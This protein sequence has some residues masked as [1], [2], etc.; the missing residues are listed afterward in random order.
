MV[1]RTVWFCYEGKLIG[2]H[3]L[4]AQPIGHAPTA[5]A[6][7]EYGPRKAQDVECRKTCGRR[8]K[9]TKILRMS[10]STPRLALYQVS[11]A[12]RFNGRFLCTFLSSI[13]C[14]AVAHGASRVLLPGTL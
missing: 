5:R 13:H 10:C 8:V 6:Q 4:H 1:D 7:A 2:I 3:K 11:P 12:C 9:R 14:W